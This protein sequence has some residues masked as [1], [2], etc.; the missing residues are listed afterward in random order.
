MKAVLVIPYFSNRVTFTPKLLATWNLYRF[1]VATAYFCQPLFSAVECDY[2]NRGRI[3]FLAAGELSFVNVVFQSIWCAIHLVNYGC[4]RYYT[5]P[6]FM[7]VITGNYNKTS[8]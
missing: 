1:H 8:L 6:P 7:A 4:W 2:R 3:L 5:H